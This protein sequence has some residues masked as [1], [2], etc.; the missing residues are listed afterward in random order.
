MQ[1]WGGARKIAGRVL[2]LAP[3][4]LRRRLLSSSPPQL[5]FPKAAAII[6][7]D[8][9][10]SGSIIDSN[11]SFLCKTLHSRGVDTVRV[12]YVRDDK[13]EIVESVLRLKNMVGEGGWI[14]T[15][16]GIGP[17]HDDVTYEAI[18]GA[19]SL[20]LEVHEE[21]LQRMTA[22]YHGRGLEITD[23]RK[24]MATLPSPC[25]VRFTESLSVP[26]VP[27]AIVHNVLILPGIPR[28]FQPMI[29]AHKHH[30]SGPSFH[31]MDLYTKVGEG[32]MAAALSSVV[33]KVIMLVLC[34]AVTLSQH[35]HVHI[36]SYPSVQEGPWLV[37]IG[38]E[39][40]NRQ[41]VEEA[42]AEIEQNVKIDEKKWREEE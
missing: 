27:L 4:A 38:V 29:A 5:E 40:R 33:S 7:G 20:P 37:R 17:T 35:P 16:G 36:G 12:E 34:S 25:Q 31:A 30:F 6:I 13:A 8:E 42:A 28:L 39:G 22:Y 1:R 15:S 18:A 21:T 41:Q 24:R 10:L 2:P 3:H 14:F 11:S 9:I 19:F 23:A 32:D 26:W